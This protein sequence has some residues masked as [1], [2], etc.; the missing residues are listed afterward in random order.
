MLL[1]PLNLFIAGTLLLLSA[2]P[3]IP[4]LS[5]ELPVFFLNI[6]AMQFISLLA[7]WAVFKRPAW[8]FWLLAPAF[9]ALPI[10]IYLQRY[11]GQ[12]ISPH[13]LGVIIESS[14]EEAVEFL[15]NKVWLVGAAALIM[16]A[17]FVLGWRAAL[18][19]RDLDWTDKSRWVILGLFGIGLALWLYGLKGGVPVSAGSTAPSSALRSM[20][21]RLPAWAQIRIDTEVFGKTW[22]FGLIVHAYDFWN[23]RKY[24]SELA[25]KSSRFK[26][27]A[28]HDAPADRPEI[29]IM[30]IGESSR[31][32]R[33][34]VN[35]YR[36]ETNPL[37]GA[38][39]NLVSLSDVITSV[40][41]TRLSVPVL[42]SRKPAT[43]SLKAGFSEKSFITAFKE[44]GF[45]TWWLSNQMSFGKFDT[46]VS[47]FAQE[48]DVRQ[49]ANLG[50]VSRKSNY[51]EVLLEP[52]TMAMRDPAPRKLIVLHTL[53]NHWNYSHRHPREYDKWQPSLYG[54][55][56]PAYTSPK[57]KTPIN[58]SYDNSILYT[59]W[60]LSQV[61]GSLKSSGKLTSLMYISDHGQTLYDGSCNLAF[62]G[63][64][65]QYEFHVPA[66]VWYSDLYRAAYPGKIERLNHNRRAKLSTENIFHSLLDMADIRYPAEQLERSLFSSRLKPHKRYVDSYGWADYDNA[67]MTGDCREVIDKGKPLVREK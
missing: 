14:P 52:L 63:H 60:F 41:A 12:G 5:G 56:R 16:I 33:W 61:I 58:N 29:V 2:A 26:F 17:W 67:V 13:H 64:N 40:S 66:L 39:A 47:V 18:R 28:H 22:P 49:F 25:E 11:F 42:M 45:K 31:Y 43:Q 27:G 38:E 55:D 35:G 24:L 48:A 54:I 50:S 34:S 15:G 65:T 7:V 23:E 20:P 62:H 57:L 8:F 3:L 37:L 51:D 44:A 10:E 32:D 9:I 30:V 6:V 4:M 59:D 1:R 53:G 46:P 19:T 36:R 21:P